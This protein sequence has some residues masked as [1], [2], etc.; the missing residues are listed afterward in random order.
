MGTRVFGNGKSDLTA[1]VNQCLMFF[2]LC[3]SDGILGYN[4]TEMPGMLNQVTVADIDH[5]DIKN[6]VH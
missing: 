3:I 4:L 1:N 5:K 6:Q 2:F